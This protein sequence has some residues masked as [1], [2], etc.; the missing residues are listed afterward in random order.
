MSR[1]IAGHNFEAGPLGNHCS[2]LAS[3][4]TVCGKNLVDILGAT[5]ADIGKP[6]W[7]HTGNLSQSEYAQIVAERD[8][9]YNAL[10]TV[11]SPRG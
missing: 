2:G 9:I 6:G 11:A 3:D 10:G 8:R 7:A 5:E 1:V 4:G